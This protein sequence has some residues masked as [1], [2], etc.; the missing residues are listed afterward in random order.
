MLHRPAQGFGFRG[1][2]FCSVIPFMPIACRSK[3]NPHLDDP[4]VYSSSSTEELARNPKT[5]DLG[6]VSSILDARMV[7]V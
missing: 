6:T 5:L 1:S 3:E 2:G 4:A 7:G